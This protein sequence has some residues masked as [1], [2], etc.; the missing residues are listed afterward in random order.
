MNVRLA[1]NYSYKIHF[2]DDCVN[3]ANLFLFCQQGCCIVYL[4]MTLSKKIIVTRDPI[5]DLKM[6]EANHF[7]Q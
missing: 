4:P 6:D 2:C 5:N 7:I 3:V 1:L